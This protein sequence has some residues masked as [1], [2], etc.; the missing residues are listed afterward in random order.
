[1]PSFHPVSISEMCANHPLILKHFDQDL[2]V[3]NFY[4]IWSRCLIKNSQCIRTLSNPYVVVGNVYMN[5]IVLTALTILSVE[6]SLL[7][8]FRTKQNILLWKNSRYSN[9]RTYYSARW[10]LRSILSCP[11][12]CCPLSCPCSLSC[13]VPVLVAVLSPVLCCPVPVMSCPILYDSDKQIWYQRDVTERHPPS[14]HTYI[15]S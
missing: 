15:H 14:L 2:V 1:M 8:A 3:N 4:R 12:L 7:T 13:P 11:V 9:W 10:S 5:S 6:C